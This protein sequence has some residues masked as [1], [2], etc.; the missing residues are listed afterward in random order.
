MCKVSFNINITFLIYYK[1]SGTTK[2]QNIA[3]MFLS[4]VA[5]PGVK[6]AYHVHYIGS[7]IASALLFIEPATKRDLL[8]N[9]IAAGT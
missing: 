4:I 5:L 3:I 6:W 8:I 2:P 7:C 1:C 9:P